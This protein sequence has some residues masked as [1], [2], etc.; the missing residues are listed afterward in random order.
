MRQLPAQ[1]ILR[2]LQGIEEA[3]KALEKAMEKP[4]LASEPREE[5][6]EETE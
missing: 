1:Q 6:S 2:N 3:R 4:A 5:S